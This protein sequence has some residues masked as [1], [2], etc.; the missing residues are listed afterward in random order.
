MRRFE[1]L[2]V[3]MKDDRVLTANGNWQGEVAQGEPGAE[4]SCP[5]LFAWL[6]EAGAQGWE[7]VAVDPEETGTAQ[8]Y[9]KRTHG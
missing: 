5:S 4:E 7:M 1:Y 6:A 3:F 9:F 2:V 8:L